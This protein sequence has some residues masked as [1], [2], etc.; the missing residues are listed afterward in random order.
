MNV[1]DNEELHGRRT[2]CKIPRFIPDEH[3]ATIK[4]LGVTVVGCSCSCNQVLEVMGRVVFYS[5][6]KYAVVFFVFFPACKGSSTQRLFGSMWRLLCASDTLSF[7]PVLIAL[8]SAA[9]G[10]LPLISRFRISAHVFYCSVI[11]VYLPSIFLSRWVLL[12]VKNFFFMGFS[13]PQPPSPVTQ[14]LPLTDGYV[15]HLLML[16]FSYTFP[17]SQSLLL[18]S[19]F[20]GVSS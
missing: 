5:S 20:R 19:H 15:P 6:K 9:R 13:W 4:A 3:P 8:L 12:C 17:P 18:C 2:I 11:S 1:L 16:S 14:T 7:P 10:C